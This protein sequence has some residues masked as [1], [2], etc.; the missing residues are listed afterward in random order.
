M[1]GLVGAFRVAWAEGGSPVAGLLE[2]LPDWMKHDFIGNPLWLW[3]LALIVTS[4]SFFV[5]M[6]VRSS[7]TSRLKKRAEKTENKFDDAAAEVLGNTHVLFLL[8]V[9]ILFGSTLLELGDRWTALRQILILVA[10]VQ[11]GIWGVAL[12]MVTLTR[13]REKKAEDPSARTIIGALGFVGKLAVWSIVLLLALQNLGVEVGTL[14]AVGGIG[15]IAFALAV[16]GTLADL[17]ASVTILLDKPFQVG[18]Y[19]V[20]GDLMGEVEHVGLKTTRIK[21]LWGEQL[22]FSNGDLLGS[23]IKN[24]KKMKDRR[25]SF[26]LGVTYQTPHAKLAA[27]PDLIREIVSSKEKVRFDRAHFAS[28]GD[29]ALNFAVVYHVLDPGYGLFMDIQQAINL[30]IFKKFEEEKIEFAYPTQTIYVNKAGVGP[31]S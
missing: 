23:R 18:D 15:G 11:G 26:T 20:V 10:L 8:A 27:I 21:S 19:I 13:W 30:Q 3:I 4:L 28:Y 17:F 22:V 16:Q 25:V 29:S 24:Y 31:A 5:L 1:S 2:K 6:V 7:V 12:L 14:L 9:S